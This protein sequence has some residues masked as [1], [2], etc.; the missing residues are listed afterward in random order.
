[1]STSRSAS[2][3]LTPRA[4]VAHWFE[5]V[6]DHLGPAYLRYSFTY[7]TEQEVTFLV[8][9]LGLAAGMQGCS[10][11][12]VGPGRHALAL[13]RRGIEVRRPRHLADLHRAGP[14]RGRRG[15]RRRS[16]RGD[17]R[18]HGL[19]RRVRCGAVA[20]PG[21]LRPRGGQDRGAPVDAG[22][23]GLSRDGPGAQAWR[24]GWRSARSRRISRFATSRDSDLRCGHGS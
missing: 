6:A 12:V 8:D 5:A 18:G 9:A 13:A 14:Q 4:D 1:M 21:R 20:V 2:R 7:G 3:G 11:S 23:G 10:M 24:A 19:R 22:R 17:A 16:N 15:C